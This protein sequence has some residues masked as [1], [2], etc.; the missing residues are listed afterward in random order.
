[1][2]YDP[3]VGRTPSSPFFA[4]GVGA[5]YL[6][7]ALFI[8]RGGARHYQRLAI[9][10]EKRALVLKLWHA[11]SVV[12]VVSWLV[13]AVTGTYALRWLAA[14]SFL[15]LAATEYVEAGAA[16]EA[17]AEKWAKRARRGA[18]LVALMLLWLLTRRR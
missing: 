3:A 1:F 17:E 4:R 18:V 7:V 16:P 6:A 5:F 2:V 14:L 13:T 9:P 12:L 15:G 10:P 8:W 11:T